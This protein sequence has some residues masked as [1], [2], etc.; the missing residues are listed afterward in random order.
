MTDP[1]TVAMGSTHLSDTVVL[2]DMV[3]VSEEPAVELLCLADL[4]D[5]IESE[6]EAHGGVAKDKD[7]LKS[8]MER[9]DGEASE[10]EDYEFFDDDAN[11]TRNLV[12]TDGRTYALIV[13]CWSKGKGS[14]IHDHPGDGCWMSILKGGLRETH[15]K[16]DKGGSEGDPTEKPL[17]KVCENL[18]CRDHSRSGVQCAYIDDHVALHKVENASCSDKAVSL[19]LYS[20]PPSF[21][22]VWLDANRADLSSQGR[23][24]CFF[25]KYGEKC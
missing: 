23:G 21:C 10:S 24:D 19:H 20:P 17:K 7:K 2:K 22:N 9:F 25:S 3:H 8:I 11:Y 4:V 13:L 1:L 5:E 18:Y 15:F 6:L 14:P 12:A 16:L